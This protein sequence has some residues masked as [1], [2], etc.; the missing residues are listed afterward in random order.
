MENPSLLRQ[1]L[2]R[3]E[4]LFPSSNQGADPASTVSW[5][6][7]KFAVDALQGAIVRSGSTVLKERYEERLRKMREES[8]L[9]Y[10]TPSEIV[11]LQCRAFNEVMDQF[12]EARR[13]VLA[14]AGKNPRE[15]RR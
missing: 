8:H 12:D 9:S 1:A 13:M 5:P 4:R 7:E 10:P 3:L 15:T 14:R 11:L 6:E 2:L